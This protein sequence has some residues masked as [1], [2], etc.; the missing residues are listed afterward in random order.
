MPVIFDAYS[1]AA[2]DT[3]SPA[4]WT[5]T[6]VGTASLVAVWVHVDSSNQPTITAVKYGG[7]NCTRLVRVDSF[8]SGNGEQLW[9]LVD[10]PRGPQTVEITWTGGLSVTIYGDAITVTGSDKVR[11][12][13]GVASAVSANSPI[14]VDVDALKGDLVIDGAILGWDAT[15]T[16]NVGAGQT[17]NRNDNDAASSS[18]R[19][20]SMEVGVPPYVTMS[21][22]F[23]GPSSN[24]WVI[25]ATAIREQNE[26]PP[27]PV[28][29][30]SC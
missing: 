28:V 13:G 24:D 3:S 22:T 20:R 16:I 19:M 26:F 12:F 5:H 2:G 8:A 14:T 18:S 7:I 11:P 6:P 30:A 4:S 15:P 29:L 10:P 17:Q 1:E 27:S 25:I 21:W 23:T 9:Y